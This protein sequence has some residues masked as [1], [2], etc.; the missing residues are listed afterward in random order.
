[1]LAKTI[2]MLLAVLLLTSGALSAAELP[3]AV[4]SSTG[5]FLCYGPRPD[6]N[7]PGI[8]VKSNMVVMRLD[9]DVL[10][11]TAERIKQ[12]LLGELLANDAWQGRITLTIQPFAAPEQDIRIIATRNGGQ[13]QYQVDFPE[14]IQPEKLVRGVVRVLLQELSNRGNQRNAGEIPFWLSEGA[15]TQLLA[16]NG[17]RLFPPAQ[18]QSVT[19]FYRPDPLL[20]IREHL[21]ANTPLSFQQLAHPSADVLSSPVTVTYSVSAQLLFYHLENLPGGRL[22]ILEFLRLLPYNLNWETS[23]L[24]AFPGKFGSLLDVEKWWA[25]ITTQFTSRRDGNLLPL[26]ASLQRLGEALTT[27]AQ[28]SKDS[29]SLPTRVQVPLQQVFSQ[30]RVQQQQIVVNQKMAALLALR[31]NLAIEAQLL[32]DGYRNVLSNYAARYPAIGYAPSQKGAVPLTLKSLVDE[33]VNKLNEL[34]QQ[35]TNLVA[36]ANAVA[37]G[38]K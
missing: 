18:T 16:V 29:N 21:A 32:D 1:M 12:A 31:P 37:A 22:A 6:A 23:F 4:R 33:T 3:L 27:P 24:Q 36:K 10:A 14:N 30:W 15:T 5:Q 20:F 35:R 2:Q 7:I 13:W 19:Q 34:D 17:N 9:A 28:V 11:V 26:N 38:A 25:I 8:T